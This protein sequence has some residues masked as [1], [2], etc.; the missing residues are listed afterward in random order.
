MKK[1]LLAVDFSESCENALSYIKKLIKEKDV[2][3]D[4]IHIYG[5]PIRTLTSMTFDLTE[6]LIEENKRSVE[7]LL[8][9]Q[10]ELIPV[11]NRGDI[12]PVYGVYASSEIISKA[13]EVG[14][15]LIVMALRQKYSM[16]DR[17]IGTVTA[18][19]MSK[20]K[21]PVLAIPNGGKYNAKAKIVLPTK[22]PFASKLSNSMSKEL[23]KLFDLCTLYSEIQLNVIHIN[24]GAQEELQ[25]TSTDYP[26]ISIVA[27]NA[28]SVEAGIKRILESNEINMIAIENENRTFWERLYHS[29]LT[30][31]LLFQARLPILIVPKSS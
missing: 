7:R 5:L 8:K 15:D 29:S 13:E 27:S 14:A 2:S 23:C 30:R 25:F 28:V 1:I 10:S 11:N 16:I 31:K 9:E 19:T 6:N 26:R 24:K 20:S 21:V 17:F 22:E 12:H 4:L 3:V 18:N